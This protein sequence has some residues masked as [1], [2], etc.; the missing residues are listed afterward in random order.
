MLFLLGQALVTLIIHRCVALL[1]CNKH[2]AISAFFI[3]SSLLNS[4]LNV[5]KCDATMAEYRWYARL[6]KIVM[7]F[8]SFA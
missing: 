3:G 6:K 4:I 8:V 1:S 5:Q 7:V 2:S